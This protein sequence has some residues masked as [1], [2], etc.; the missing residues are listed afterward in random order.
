MGV[1]AYG[2]ML[3]VHPFV[4][5]E[6]TRPML[7]CPYFKSYLLKDGTVF[8]PRGEWWGGLDV[9]KVPNSQRRISQ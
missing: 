9:R 2:R 6:P 5:H 4:N 3:W 1:M 8:H 7:T